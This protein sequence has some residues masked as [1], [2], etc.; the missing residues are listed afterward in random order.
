M[1]KNWFSTEKS[2]AMYDRFFL[3]LVVCLLA[4]G[5]LMVTSASMVI[6][7][8]Q[9]GQPFHYMVRQ[10]I[11]LAL[12][13]ISVLIALRIPSQFWQR[14][15]PILLGIALVLLV[16][17]L[18]PHIGHSVNGSRR[19]IGFGP[20]NLQVSEF[21]KMSVV[22]F[23]AGFLVRREEEVRTR[24]SGFAKPM[25][26]Y[27]LIALLL[28]L[29]PDFGATAV[30]GCTILAM[31]F[32]AGV[33][34]WQFIV[35][36]SIV[37]VAFVILIITAPY[38]LQ[39]LTTFI[40]PWATAFGSGYQLT[41]SLIAFG[42]GGWFGVGL[43]S[44]V[45]KLF[46]LPEAHTD[47]LFAVLAEE[48]GLFAV[49]L[50]IVIYGLLIWR[51]MLIGRHAQLQHRTFQAYTAFGFAVWLGMQVFVNMGVNAGMLPTKGLTLPLISYG[52]SSL[53]IDCIAIGILLRI[54]FENRANTKG[55][56]HG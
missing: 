53:L 30:I 51:I 24:L 20:L 41:Q 3:V 48:L 25:I 22:L 29:E 34:L 13:F 36:I 33:R 23:F 6:S 12:G 35:L 9:Y 46:Y 28:L 52:G 32:L 43:G 45:Q 14:Y 19:W 38:R 54:D 39:R 56:Q 55:V 15:S 27:L 2:P 8:R 4:I 7:Q 31:L 47:F 49:L 10:L 5:I 11:Y 40:D 26:L 1:F 37:A 18:I 42:R 16:L 17:V 50:L 21:V 44:S